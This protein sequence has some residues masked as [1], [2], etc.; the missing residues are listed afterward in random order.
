[1]QLNVEILQTTANVDLYVQRGFCP[2]NLA[3]FTYGSFNPSTNT[4]FIAIATN[5]VPEPLSAGDW[6]IAVY[7]ADNV[8]ANYTL[9]VTEILAS[10]II[11]L[12]NGI[13]YSNNVV[14]STSLVSYPVQYYVYR[15]TTNA[16]R[17]Q[18]EIR[19]TDGDVNIY[20]RETLP[21]PTPSN[22]PYHS[23]NENLSPELISVLDT[24]VPLPLSPG[25][26]FITVTNAST[27]AA[28]YTIVASESRSRGD[29]IDVSR[30]WLVTNSLCIT[31]VGTVAGV[32]YYVVGKPDWTSQAWL[33]VSGTLRATGPSLTWCTPLPT[34]YIFFDLRE[35]LSPLSLDNPVTLTNSFASSNG[36]TLCWTAPPNLLY[37]VYYSD[38]LFPL[39][40][41]PYPDYV[42]S[43]TDTYKFIDDGS[44]TGGLNT[45]RYYQVILLTPP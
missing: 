33:P 13:P 25:D 31:W 39:Y 28:G 3:S 43:S 24:S 15:V 36:L 10:E 29:D 40:W 27:V 45:N 35:G 1:V 32:N 18:F 19:Q 44:K 8:A 21:L 14:A 6:F 2:T 41:K 12:T 37:G 23:A 26:W 17:A 11:R 38:T 20:A 5:S 22:S 34:P 4:E 9:R 16:A 42:T 7:N 30:V